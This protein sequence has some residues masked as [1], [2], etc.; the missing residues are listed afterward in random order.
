MTKEELVILG[1]QGETLLSAPVFREA[2]QAVRDNLADRFFASKPEDKEERERIYNMRL[3][4]DAV[5]GTIQA[6]VAAKQ[7]YE[8]DEQNNADD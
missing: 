4:L 1:G 7:Q 5:I 8:Q 3:T 2:V 6:Y